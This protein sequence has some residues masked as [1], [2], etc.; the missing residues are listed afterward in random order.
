[1]FFTP[2]RPIKPLPTR[3]AQGYFVFP[4][5]HQSSVDAQPTPTPQSTDEFLAEEKR[6]R[7]AALDEAWAARRLRDEAARKRRQE[8]EAAEVLKN[9]MAWVASG[10]ILRDANYERDYVR[11]EALRKEIALLAHE[12]VL[13]ERWQKYESGWTA[14][15]T[16]NGVV[17]F[18]D[19]P[20]PTTP[21]PDSDYD[22]VILQDLTVDRIRAF[23]LDPLE[24]R[25]STVTKKERTRASLLRWHPDK[26]TGLISRV[27]PDEMKAVHEG[28]HQVILALQSLN[29]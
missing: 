20:W 16:S 25:G 7:E 12:R 1:M 29:S 6:R 14:L 22:Y 3:P 19:I 13:T 23:L 4:P 26:M 28:V 11:T 10:G 21:R 2:T 5:S 15:N 18:A 27:A 17:R 24:V 9:E 8:L